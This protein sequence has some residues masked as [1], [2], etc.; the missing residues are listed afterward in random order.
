MRAEL[1][2]DRQAF[3]G[4]VEELRVLN[5]ATASPAEVAQ[6]A[7][8]LHHAY[9]AVEAAL[10]RIARVIERGLPEGPDWHSALLHAM[11]LDIPSV[12]PAVLSG[13]SVAALRK[14]LAFRH[15][16]RHAYAAEWDREQLATLRQCAVDAGPQVVADLGAF[17]AVLARLAAELGR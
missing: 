9:G 10:A 13:Q 14:L 8:A 11:T 17:E 6:L 7:V 4:R 3:E 5:A 12:R 15:F 2:S 1:G 16:F